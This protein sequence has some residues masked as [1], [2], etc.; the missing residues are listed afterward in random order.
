MTATTPWQRGRFDARKGPGRVLFGRMYED[1]SIERAAF[2]HG[3]RVFAIASAGCTAMALAPHHEVVA[4]DINP[5]QLEY[6]ARRIAGG[7]RVLGTAER[8][9]GIGRALLPLAGWREERV[10]EFLSLEDPNVQTAFFREHLDT[11]RFRTGFDAMLSLPSLRAV[12]SAA[13]LS[14][15]P[16]H[17]G[18]TLRARLERGFARHP[19]AS[20]PYARALLLGDST[21]TLHR[22]DLAH[23]ITLVHSDAAAHLEAVKGGSFDAFTLSN[24][25]D[26]AEPAYTERLF[27]AIRHAASPHA[28][29]VLRSF[30]EPKGDS[31]WNYAREDRS[32]LWGTV[33]VR[34]VSNLP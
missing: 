27:R 19:N 1:A 8:V 3:A 6:A 14:F 12:Y 5:V 10:R 13:L 9:M 23:R 2:P 21:D 4:C 30:A 33:D 15:L 17:F 24:I 7:P 25:L 20:N 34:T 16:E 22:E 31:P 26:G 11:W 29:L 32:M 18:A 28:V